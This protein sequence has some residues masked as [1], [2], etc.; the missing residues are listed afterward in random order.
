MT[1]RGW[2]AIGAVLLVIVGLVFLTPNQPPRSPGHRSDSDAPDGTSA[3]LQ[4]AGRLDHSAR[5]MR[6]SFSLPAGQGLLFVFTPTEPFTGPEATQ[7][8]DWIERGGVLVYASAELDADAELSRAL[9][10]SPGAVSF[11]TSA[12]TA[13]DSGSIPLVA[14]DSP[15]AGVSQVSGGPVAE[16]LRPAPRQ[17]VILRPRDGGDPVGIVFNRGQGRVVVIGDPQV[18]CNGTIGSTDNGRLAADLFSLV[19][20]GGP[21]LFDE[22]HHGVGAATPSA[23]D[24]VGTPAGSAVFWLFLFVYLGLLL[25][26]RAFGPAIPISFDRGR[27]SAEYASAVGALLRRAKARAATYGLLS[28]ATHRALAERVGIGRGVPPAQL[29]EV[30]GTRA[31]HLAAELGIAAGLAARA[32]G[33]E[34]ALL[35]AARRLHALAY[36][37]ARP[38]R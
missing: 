1:G 17:L 25:R 2:V 23:F 27:S 26:S 3:L 29:A 36:P 9:S 22:F 14:T 18:L 13:G 21:V 37:S 11:A 12:P 32:A 24:W 33:S 31:P 10:I 19:A 16:G 15:F 38:K 6:G 35:D 20:A 8:V 4:Y 30:L 7:L 5:P 28:E 34:K